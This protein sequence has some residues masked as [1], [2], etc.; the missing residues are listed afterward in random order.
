MGSFNLPIEMPL[1]ALYKNTSDNEEIE[2]VITVINLFINRFIVL[3]NSVCNVG[4]CTFL[5][6]V[7]N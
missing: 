6:V 4:I 2:A 3:K 5:C 7:F 1:Y